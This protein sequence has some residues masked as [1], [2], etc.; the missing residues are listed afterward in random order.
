MVKAA[1]PVV[2]YQ[3]VLAPGADCP[4]S[5]RRERIAGRELAFDAR[6]P[7]CRLQDEA[8]RVYATL[9]GF[10]FDMRASRRLD[11]DTE[12]L[13]PALTNVDAFER[14]VLPRLAGAFLI[15]T[16]DPLPA[17]VY[18]DPGG[19]LPLVFS[20]A[21][22][23][24]AAS[25]ALLLDDAAYEARFN[26]PLHDAMV[27]SEGVGGWI[28]GDLT[29]HK[30]VYRV[31]PNHCL[32]LETWTSHRYWPRKDTFE[33]W[34]P[35]GEA[36][37]KAAT[38]MLRFTTLASQGFRVALSL[39]AG[40]DSRLL[41][42][43]A[44][45]SLSRCSFYTFTAPGG[46]IDVDVA[47]DLARRFSLRHQ[48]LT[49]EGATDEQQAIWDRTVGH[50]MSEQNRLTH[51]TLHKVD[52]DAV[53]VGMYGELGRCRLYRQDRDSINAESI[54]ARFV[55]SRLTLPDFPE[56]LASVETWFDGISDLPNSVILD[57]AFLELKFGNWAMGQ[58]PMHN[59]IRLHLL[60]FA[61]R[62]VF[63]A[64]LGVE[65]SEKGTEEL[66]RACIERLWPE[67]LEVPVNKYGNYRDYLAVLGKL[68]SPSRVRRFLRDRFA[69]K[70]AR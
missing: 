32:D 54:D 52:A 13:H 40:F 2:D 15:V 14:E 27:V 34:M 22:R 24:A 4:A 5:F 37:E 20:P 56:S 1:S 42:A 16:H 31:L 6:L 69:R 53:M 66:F 7:L 33:S 35:L 29:A 61:Q 48:L 8:G 39:T 46:Q 67:L 21:D 41:L 59:S 28:T 58:H 3:Y 70:L 9:I 44:K 25:T 45:D 19:S 26:H 17:R 65:P 49:V 11:R 47:Q 64:F 43:S 36:A 62:D 10:G 18:L 50:C 55:L 51:T 23:R 63:E 60:P 30:G 12:V 68:S 38:A 57:L